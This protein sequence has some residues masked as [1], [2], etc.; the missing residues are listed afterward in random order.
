VDAQMKFAWV[1][2]GSFLMGSKSM[3][4][5]PPHRVTVKEGFW[6]GIFPVT[7]AQ[8][9]AVMGYNSSKSPVDEHPADT[10]SWDDAMEFCKRMSELTGKEVRL[11]TDAEWEYA[12]RSGT[13]TRFYN[14]NNKGALSKIGWFNGDEGEHDDLDVEVE[15]DEE[16]DM[17]G[18]EEE[19]AVGMGSSAVGRLV[20]HLACLWP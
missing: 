9:R 4:N 1:P 18:E 5:N 2:P 11:P 8:F 3:E 7:Q 13:G 16:F 10:V 6:M 17:Q 20:G 12:C 19:K 14:G 15:E